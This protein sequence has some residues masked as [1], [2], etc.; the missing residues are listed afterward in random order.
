[1]NAPMSN[2]IRVADEVWL[3]VASLHQKYAEREDFTMNE[4]MMQAESRNFCNA[5]RLRP[6]VKVHAYL[7]CV[8]NKPP[9]PGRYRMLFETKRGYRRLFRSSDLYHPARKGGKDRP[10][11]LELPNS[12]H[13]YLDWY[14]TE[15]LSMD[16]Y[17]HEDP[18]MSLR[19]FGK[20]I[21]VSEGA[22]EYVSKLR[23]S[24]K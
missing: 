21:W 19:G 22:D 9:N 5:K 15:Y 7:H 3:V 17:S 6:S 13:S 16:P 20:E 4:I 14:E 24:W 1:M 11:R 23:S 12:L 18:L 8:A 10:V 2:S